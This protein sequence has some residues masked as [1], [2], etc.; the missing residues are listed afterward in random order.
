MA[1]TQ[2]DE[3]EIS[4]LRAAEYERHFEACHPAAVAKSKR[5]RRQWQSQSPLQT[6]NS[7]NIS[8]ISCHVGAQNLRTLTSA[9]R[10]RP[11]PEVKTSSHEA[12]G[13]SPL[14]LS[15]LHMQYYAYISEKEHHSTSVNSRLY[16]ALISK[17]PSSLL[18][19]T[20]QNVTPRSRSSIPI[21]PS[22]HISLP[23][24]LGM[25]AKKME[26]ETCIS[27]HQRLLVCK[28]SYFPIY[29]PDRA[30]A[31]AAGRLWRLYQRLRYSL[32]NEINCPNHAT[33]AGAGGIT[34]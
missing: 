29:Q 34:G 18:A 7:T 15:L 31:A 1:D 30:G 16:T 27:I 10:K 25:K 11:S 23:F 12:T 8:F 5:V 13:Y 26:G 24:V 33:N 22:H 28:I 6:Y 21:S 32:T 4:S 20:P 3:V 9:Q 19:N 14:Q 17:S 2:T